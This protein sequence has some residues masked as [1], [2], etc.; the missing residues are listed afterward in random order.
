M[1]LLRVERG[2]KAVKVSELFKAKILARLRGKSNLVLELLVGNFP[3]FWNFT[4]KVF[5]GKL[6][7]SCYFSLGSLLL[8]QARVSS[9]P[10][11]FQFSLKNLRCENSTW[12]ARSLPRGLTICRKYFQFINHDARHTNCAVW[13]LLVCLDCERGR[14]INFFLRIFPDGSDFSPAEAHAEYWWGRNCADCL[15]KLISFVIESAQRKNIYA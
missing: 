11:Q 10:L 3:S 13:F 2:S 5:P 7:D 6:L 1:R 9:K 8:V 12:K 14:R 4:F 15:L